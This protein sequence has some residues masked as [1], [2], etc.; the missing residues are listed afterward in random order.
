ME[1]GITIVMNMG[2]KRE[3]AV[4]AATKPKTKV[5]TTP[6]TMAQTNTRA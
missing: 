5:E 1:P 4:E 2:T 3:L 6:T